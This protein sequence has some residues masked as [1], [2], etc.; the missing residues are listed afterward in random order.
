M[1]I[2]D[3][4]RVN[5][6]I[7][8]AFHHGWI[9]EIARALNRGLLPPDYYALPEQHAAGFGPDVLTLEQV[10]SGDGAAETET[11]PS[12]TR[13]GAVLATP[14]LAPTAE[15]DMAFYRR[16]QKTVTVRHVSG[17][18]IV[19]MVEIVSPGN[20]AARRPLRAFVAKAAELLDQIHLLILDLLPRGR[21]DP[22]GIHGEIWQEIA[23][24]EYVPPAD[25][26]LTLAAYES[27]LTVR[28]YVVPAA[29]GQL[30][31]DMPLFLEPEKAVQVPLE[32]TYMAAFNEVPRR[33][34]RVLE[35]PAG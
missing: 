11:T 20:K 1:P 33:W 31:P 13:G 3:W 29:V 19:A 9:E 34:R 25:L 22:E 24:Q 2:H 18:R 5:A 28:A 4:T 14:K 6:G 35:A 30:M 32:A 23:G 12:P 15:T 17:D 21:R 26:P 7:L 8:H 10:D 16:K 27:G